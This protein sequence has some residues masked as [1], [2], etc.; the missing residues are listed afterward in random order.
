MNDE[1]LKKRLDR[2]EEGLKIAL[3]FLAAIGCLIVFLA[4][5]VGMK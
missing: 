5:T 1:E 2:I 3:L 4:I